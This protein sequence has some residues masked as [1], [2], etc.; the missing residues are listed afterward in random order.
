MDK[1][2]VGKIGEDTAV[3][4]LV[5]KGYKVI[6]RNFRAKRY[7]EVDIIAHSPDGGWLVFVEVKTRVGDSFGKPEEAVTFGKMREL[8]KMVDY[9]YNLKQNVKVAPRIDVVA[10]SL[11]FDQTLLDLRHFPNVTL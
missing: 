2:T 7:G 3:S 10:V 8:K 6:Q 1:R 9:F 5:S 11:A 4:Y